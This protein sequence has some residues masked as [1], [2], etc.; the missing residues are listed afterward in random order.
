[1]VETSVN[2]SKALSI[3]PS[4]LMPLPDYDFDPMESAIPWQ[5]CILRGWKITFST[6]TGSVP[7]CDGNKLTGPLPGYLSASKNARAAYQQMIEDPAYQ[8]PIPYATIDPEHYQAMLLPGGDGLRVR[9]YLD[10]TLLQSKVLQFWQQEKLIGAI[11]HGVLVLA[12][13]IDPQ[14]GHSVLY[15]SKVTATPKVLDRLA[16]R[17]DSWVVKHGYVMYKHCVADEVRACLEN[18][19]N[20]SE[21]NG[22]FTPYSVVDGNLV[23][24][25]WFLDAELFAQRFTETLQHKMIIDS[26]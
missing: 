24:A 11:C 25:R 26:N 3:T 19:Q 20:Y 23:T 8:H 7:Q 21:G 13:T 2:G 5:A 17:L 18:Q 16:Y 6:E 1:M 9:Q 12:R 4:I 15:S 14:S 22:L 10:S